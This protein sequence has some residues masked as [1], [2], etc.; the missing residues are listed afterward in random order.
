M[1]YYISISRTEN[2]IGSVLALKLPFNFGVTA[3]RMVCLAE[4]VAYS[5]AEGSRM[6]EGVQV[7]YQLGSS[8]LKIWN[9]YRKF[10]KKD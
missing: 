4:K 3:V 7:T 8:I 6:H 10:K 2:Y 9:A 1:H 5:T